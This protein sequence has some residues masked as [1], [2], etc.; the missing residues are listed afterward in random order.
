MSTEF[1]AIGRRKS[2][3]ARVRIR[4]G[5]GQIVVNKRE[6]AEYFGRPTAVMVLRQ[7]LVATELIDKYDVFVNV[8]GG[9]LSGQAG[10]VRHG[11]S[12]ALLLVDP[13]LRGDLKRAGFLTRDPRCKERKKYGQRSARA[14]FQFSKR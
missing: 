3:T 9:G 11:I 2:A 1:R 12:R 5:S 8:R 13:S 7:P 10:A 4:P 6:V 14:R